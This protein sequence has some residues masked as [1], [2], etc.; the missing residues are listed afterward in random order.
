MA[1]GEGAPAPPGGT[2]AGELLEVADPLD[3]VEAEVG[4]AAARQVEAI[5]LA[6]PGPS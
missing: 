4:A 1:G 6:P 2:P 3:A 5:L